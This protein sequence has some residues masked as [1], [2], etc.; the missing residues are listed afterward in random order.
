MK[1][2]ELS[3]RVINAALEVHTRLGPGFLESLYE[4]ALMIELRKRN[5]AYE[6]QK[7]ITVKYDGEIIGTHVL[8]SI[9][10]GQIILELKACRAFEKIHFSQL[11]SYLKATGLKIG[12]LLNFGAPVLQIKRL[13]N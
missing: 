4:K 11:I 6:C 13:I 7:S 10:E 1:F 9:I 2:D 3:H 8:D 5:I 12:L